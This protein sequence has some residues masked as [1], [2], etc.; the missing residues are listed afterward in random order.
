[1]K[2]KRILIQKVYLKSIIYLFK[3]CLFNNYVKLKY[4]KRKIALDYLCVFL[5]V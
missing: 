5:I 1:M 4:V 2:Y 3:I